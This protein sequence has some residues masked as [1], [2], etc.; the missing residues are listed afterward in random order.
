M[1]NRAYPYL[2]ALIT[3][4]FWGIAPVFGK[5]G[6]AKVGPYIA[7]VFRSLVVTV[8]LLIVILVRGG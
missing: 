4:F 2:L 5:L 7:L 3:M 1:E 8:I 6:L